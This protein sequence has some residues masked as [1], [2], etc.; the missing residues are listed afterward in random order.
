MPV[1]QT[2]THPQSQQRLRRASTGCTFFAHGQRSSK[3]SSA[4]QSASSR[5]ATLSGC[6]GASPGDKTADGSKMLQNQGKFALHEVCA[7]DKDSQVSNSNS[8]LPSHLFHV[9]VMDVIL[10]CCAAS[11]LHMWLC[12]N[13][14]IHVLD[15]T[16][17]SRQ[18]TYIMACACAKGSWESLHCKGFYDAALLQLSGLWVCYCSTNKPLS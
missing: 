4:A 5:A 3:T 2:L 8:C 9:K 16:L 17:Y 6:P 10:I 13:A 7:A 1:R 15:R 12:T 11:N 14:T 18:G